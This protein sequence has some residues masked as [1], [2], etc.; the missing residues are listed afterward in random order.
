M[1]NIIT[2]FQN[3]KIKLIK[4]LRDKK[5]RD[6]E[7]LFVIDSYRDLRRALDCGYEAEFVLHCPSLHSA[8][9]WIEGLALYE[10]PAEIM[11]KASYRENPDGIIAVIRQKPTQNA[12]HLARISSEFILGLVNLMKPGN[13][14][15]LLRSADAAGFDTIF[16]IDTQ[17]DLY[18]PNLI[19]SS[20]GAVFLDN[21]YSVSSAEA[22]QFLRGAA[23]TLIAAAPDGERELYHLDISG[24]TALLLGTED[25]GL[26]A[27]WLGACDQR[28]RIPMVGSL[29]DSLNV[30]VSGAV[31]MYEILRQR[32]IRLNSYS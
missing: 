16:L 11:E 10:V 4:K 29:S 7:A 32:Q 6:Q 8:V 22:I 1:S 21:L 15:A 13:I 14:G 2:S 28:V 23:F 24:K 20:T 3:P 19:R 12:A 25:D 5:G 31:M 27:V 18:N 9:D 17:L 30:S 26:D